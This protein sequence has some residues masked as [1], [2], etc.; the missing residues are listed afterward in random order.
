[1]KDR[2]NTL[3]IACAGIFA[4]IAWVLWVK[5]CSDVN[6]PVS[7]T[8]STYYWKNLYGKEVASQKATAAQFGIEKKHL[9]DS[10]AKVYKTKEKWLQEWILATERTDADIP[11]VPGTL[12]K[13]YEPADIHY[14]ICPPVIKR[15][16]KSFHSNYYDAQVQIGDSRYLHLQRHDSLTV[17]WTK[18]EEGSIFNRRTLLQLDVSNA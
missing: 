13:E 11:E 8:D 3:I 4:V 7:L 14:N 6:N 15:M 17:L 10:L 12:I 9:A 2:T 16:K 18:V 5:S 1:M